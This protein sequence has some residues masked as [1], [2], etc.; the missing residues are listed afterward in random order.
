MAET[1]RRSGKVIFRN[2]CH[3]PAPSRAAAS[4]TSAEMF[5]SPLY[6]TTRLN[7]TPIQMLAITTETSAH[8]GDVSQ[9]TGPMPTLDSTEFTT[10]EVLLSIHD[11]VDADTIKGSNH[12]TRNS[13]RSVPERRKLRAKNTAR[14]SPMVNWNTSD[15]IVKVSV[16]RSAGQKVGSANT[17]R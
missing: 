8:C 11:Q 5:C 15:T 14:A 16:L 2:V 10:P 3:G 13:A 12:G 9:L 17:V 4:Y 1:G 7:G 6:R